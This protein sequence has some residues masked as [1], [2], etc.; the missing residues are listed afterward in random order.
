M[1][2]TKRKIIWIGVLL[3]LIIVTVR[4]CTY[5]ENT[6]QIFIKDKEGRSL[7]LHGVNVNADAKGDPLRVGWPKKQDYADLTEKWGFNFV[8][9]LVLW[10]GIE[11]KKGEYDTIYFDRIRERLDWCYDL[12]LYVVLDMHQDLY[13]L[14]YGGDGA[15]DWAIIDDG[16][17]F[18]MQS[19]W[20]LNYRQPAVIAS[21]NNFWDIS[22]GHGDLQEHYIKAVVELVK[23]FKDHPAVLGYDLYNEPT[24]ATKEAF[25]FEERYLQPFYEK[26]IPAIRKVDSENWIFYE[27]SALGVN[28]GLRSGLDVLKDPRQGEPRLA[29]F[30]H[31]Y[32][33]DYDVYDRYIG[34]PI[35]ISKWAASRNIEVKKQKAPMLIGEMGVNQTSTGSPEFMEEVLNMFDKTSSGWAYWAYVKKDKWSP[36]NDDGSNMDA[37]NLV[38]RPYPQSVAGQPSSY[39]FEIETGKF[40]LDFYADSNIKV[41]TEV[42]IPKRHYTNGWDIK[43]DQDEKLWKT[44]WDENKRVLQIFNLSDKNIEFKITIHPRSTD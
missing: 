44:N 27:P 30:P 9:Y 12:G 23:E 34:F 3:F 33:I 13:A 19:P 6:D 37:R 20:E 2:I 25:S 1:N 5:S 41:P 42:Y 35:F 43:I 8:R 7:I 4:N 16:E 14:R 21:I 26:L 22:R 31:L 11:P 18:E 28:Q 24:M 17:P 39:G 10:D 40:W 38:V 36:F 32:T 29:Y 15:P